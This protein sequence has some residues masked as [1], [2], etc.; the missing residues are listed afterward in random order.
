MLLLCAAGTAAARQVCSTH[1]HRRCAHRTSQA[2][3]AEA[4]AS[5]GAEQ[6]PPPTQIVAY[7]RGLLA[8][9]AQDATLRDIL[10][11]VHQ[12]TGAAIEAP[13]LEQRVSLQLGPLPPVLTIATLLN[14]RH[15]NYAILGGTSDQDR[16]L[17]II[18]TLEPAAP[19]PATATATSLV[20][21]DEAAKASA[22]ASNRFAEETGGDEGV[23]DNRPPSAPETRAPSSPFAATPPRE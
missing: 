10:D 11:L 14:G 1:W 7:E 6:Q 12:S 8:I 19:Q 13:A 20:P 21:E 2:K 22:R 17:R 5:H 23:W 3:P 4:P 15:L 9:T 16:L 18:V